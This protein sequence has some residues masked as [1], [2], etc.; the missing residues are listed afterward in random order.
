MND[1][2]GRTASAATSDPDVSSAP[3][4]GPEWLTAPETIRPG[5]SIESEVAQGGE[6]DALRQELAEL[7]GRLASVPTPEAIAEQ[8]VQHP[9][10]KQSQRDMIGY[11]IQ[12]YMQ[13]EIERRNAVIDQMEEAGEIAPDVADRRR[14]AT[15]RQVRDEL[16][17][18]PPDFVRHTFAEEQVEAIRTQRDLLIAQA[19]AEAGVDVDDPRLDKRDPD[20]FRTSLLRAVREGAWNAKAANDGKTAKAGEPGSGGAEEQGGRG[21]GEQGRAGTSPAPTKTPTVDVLGGAPGGKA[22]PR[23][24]PTLDDAGDI[25]SVILEAHPEWSRRRRA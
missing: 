7:K 17:Q 9:R 13:S 25:G 6:L 8:V 3:Q 11:Q 24:K 20:R 19:C 16:V 23:P 14:R 5:A 22:E 12:Q 21:A 4:I 1:S 15:T 2:T 18:N 10:L